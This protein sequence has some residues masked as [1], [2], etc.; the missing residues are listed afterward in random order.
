MRRGVA[1]YLV[2]SVVL[3]LLSGCGLFKWEKRA[4]WRDE[5]EQACLAAKAVPVTAY[6]EPAREIDGPGACGML[7]P[8]KVSAFAGGTVGLTSRA[9]LACPIISEID[10]WLLD[11]VQPAAEI[12]YGQHVAE[13][14]V[15]SYSCRSM[16]NQAGAARS[17]HSYGNAMDVMAF[18]L[19]DGREVTVERGWRASEADQ[20]FLR[21]VFLGACQIF[22]TV[23]APGSD[24]FHY[25]HIHIDLARHNGGRVICKPIIKFASRLEALPP[26][27]TPRR[28][29]QPLYAPPGQSQPA[30]ESDALEE[31]IESDQEPVTTRP[32]APVRKY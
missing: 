31:L 28:F 27:T 9:T 15:G 32:I 29:G 14:R 25:N 18:H 16:N 22:G 5:A 7:Q 17:E 26:A 11:V 8:F 12:Y 21:E 2:G 10:R 19:A 24:A 20:G 6:V 1:Q 30:Y 23:L 3:V 13:L 4:A